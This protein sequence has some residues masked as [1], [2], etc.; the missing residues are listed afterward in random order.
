[1]NPDRCAL[2]R[3]NP[4]SLLLFRTRPVN[5]DVLLSR[6]KL[7]SLKSWRYE[8]DWDVPETARLVSAHAKGISLSESARD[9]GFSRAIQGVNITETIRDLRAFFKA[10][11]TR[12]GQADS[13]QSLTEGWVAA[14]EASAPLS[15]T[16]AL[17]GLSTAEH[18]RR[19]LHD[20]Y[21]GADF[22][23]DAFVIGKI[24]LP[25]LPEGAT[26]RWT[27]LA[28]LGACCERIFTNTGATVMYERNTVTILMPRTQEN[29]V[30]VISCHTALTRIAHSGWDPAEIS[31][32]PLPA[33][34]TGL[35]YLLDSLTH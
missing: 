21:A 19:I 23:P 25:A 1:M 8:D 27:V 17:T 13:L 10:A 29:Y 9:L 18:F 15:C 14:S 3:M 12:T 35:L 6:W 11:K 28:R 20:T 30:R 34:T 5:T 32:E 4:L 31:Y 33:E 16:D 22:D 24:R 26:Q 7:A 2:I